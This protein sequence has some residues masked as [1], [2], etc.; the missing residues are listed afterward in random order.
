MSEYNPFEIELGPPPSLNKARMPHKI[1]K[2]GKFIFRLIDTKDLRNW[3][4]S[5]T[6]ALD[7]VEVI[8]EWIKTHF[9]DKGTFEFQVRW[10]GD[11]WY[12]NGNHRRRDVDNRVKFLMDVIFKRLG[13]DDSSVFKITLIKEPGR[14]LDNERCVCT[15]KPFTYPEKPAPGPSGLFDDQKEDSQK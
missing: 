8:P 9:E 1:K 5:A 7:A 6:L 3:K 4:E 11:H 14:E 12:K 2:G 15:V 10:V 13:I